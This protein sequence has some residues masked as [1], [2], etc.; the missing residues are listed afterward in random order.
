[1]KDAIKLE[2]TVYTRRTPHTTHTLIHAHAPHTHT[3]TLTCTHT[4]HTHTQA[5]HTH[6]NIYT[7]THT[8]HTHTY[9]YM[10]TH[11]T[12]IH[13]HTPHPHTPHTHTHSE[14]LILPFFISNVCLPLWAASIEKKNCGPQMRSQRGDFKPQKQSRWSGNFLEGPDIVFAPNTA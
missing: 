11:H 9:T 8:T 3:Y 6:T 1:M 2:W 13:A 7:C 5:P 14:Q 10:Y 12:H 4:P